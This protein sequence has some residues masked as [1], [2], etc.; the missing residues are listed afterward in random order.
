M[1]SISKQ[2]IA[3]YTKV[4]MRLIKGASNP[5]EVLERA[6]KT[7]SKN[8]WFVRRAAVLY[9]CKI[10]EHLATNTLDPELVT[11]GILDLPQS[12]LD[13]TYK[14]FTEAPPL[15]ERKP[16]HSKRKDMRQLPDDWCERIWDEPGLAKYRIPYAVSALTGCRPS[17]LRKGVWI[18]FKSPPPQISFVIR[19]AKVTDRSGQPSRAMKFAVTPG[20]NRFI[21]SIVAA[22]KS[23]Q[24]NQ[25]GFLVVSIQSE[26]SFSAAIT[27]ASLRLGLGG[28][29]GLSAYCLRHAFAS[30]LKQSQRSREEIAKGLGHQ[31]EKTQT[32]YGQ[33]RMAGGG[34]VA[35]QGIAAKKAVRPLKAKDVT[36]RL[37]APK[38]R[39]MR[40]N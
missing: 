21:D 1:K 32:C 34:A 4:F 11:N 38:A 27:R 36:T 6:Q 12:L 33:A 28:K 19:G 16:R 13:E 18:E 31:S 2:S 20:Q 3:D 30:T 14:I 25:Q 24:K 39:S 40:A 26:K 29:R 5:E 9:M 23:G 7:K 37:H 17:E 35:P 22:W 8:T 10:R 15:S